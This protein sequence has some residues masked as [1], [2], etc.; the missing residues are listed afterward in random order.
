MSV[1]AV[2]GGGPGVPSLRRV[3]GGRLMGFAISR[4][5]ISAADNALWEGARAIYTREA[6]SV[7]QGDFHWPGL[8]PTQGDFNFPTTDEVHA[9]ALAHG[10]TEHLHAYHDGDGDGWPL[11]NWLSASLDGGDATNAE[12]R[13]R[14]FLAGTLP[15]YAANI[16]LLTVG[17]EPIADGLSSTVPGPGGIFLREGPI[18]RKL[19]TA[20]FDIAFDEC[21]TRAPTAELILN[22]YHLELHEDRRQAMLVLA[23]DLVTRGVMLPGDGIG[24]ECHLTPW[25]AYNATQMF[26]FCTAIGNL[27]LNVHLT[28]VDIN[29]GPELPADIPT[30]DAQQ[31]DFIGEILDIYLPNPAVK[32]LT[33]WGLSDRQHHLYAD[34]GD[35]LAGRG[36][37]WDD[38]YQPKPMLATIRAKLLQQ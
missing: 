17:G 31:A 21:R 10:L 14:S 19:G 4:A 27:G 23:N 3:A 12:T 9:F 2:T 25:F 26:D 32:S 5:E 38:Q 18:G 37:P 24:I 33:F 13:L 22:D 20:Q 29:D 30:R 11:P 35:G 1:L 6:A 28:E 15:R 34:R 7:T 8:E 36:L 16:D